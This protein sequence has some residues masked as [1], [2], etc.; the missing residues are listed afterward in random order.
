MLD[1]GNFCRRQAK[2]GI[3]KCVDAALGGGDVGAK[4]V[5]AGFFLGEQ[6][7]PV[8]ALAQRNVSLEAFGDLGLKCFEIRQLPSLA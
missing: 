7:L 2:Q 6:G 8:V 5:D 1:Q 3:D 4:L